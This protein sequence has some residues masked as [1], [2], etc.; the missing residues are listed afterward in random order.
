ML[1]RYDVLP[2]LVQK[3]V[4]LPGETLP[5]QLSCLGEEDRLDTVTGAL[6]VG[7]PSHH[8]STRASLTLQ[9]DSV[10]LYVPNRLV[11]EANIRVHVGKI[12][13][14]ESAAVVIRRRILKI[15]KYLSI[16]IDSL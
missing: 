9:L 2:G 14:V 4:V 1:C 10:A 16:S 5:A 11:L 8:I 7:I 13:S 6:V 12:F 15:G 3:S